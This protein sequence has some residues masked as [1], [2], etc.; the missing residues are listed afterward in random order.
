MKRSL[1]RVILGLSTG[2][3]DSSAALVVDNHLV[4]AAEEERFVRIKHFALFPEHAIRYCLHH[5]RLSPGEVDCVAIGR[6]RWK[7][8]GH[9]LLTALRHPR[10][11]NA[12]LKHFNKEYANTSFEMFLQR[13]CL[14]HAKLVHVEHH[15]AHMASARFVCPEPNTAI[16]SFDG[17]GDFASTAIGVANGNE[18]SILDRVYFP[19]SV[20]FFYTA[21]TQFL[22]FPYFGDEFKVMGLSS[23]GKPRY[24]TELRHLICAKDPFGFELN[25]EAFPILTR[26]IRFSVSEKGQPDTAAF[27]D[28]KYLSNL[29]GIPPRQYRGPV[30]QTHS[31]LAKS[32]QQCFEEI[33]NQLLHQLYDR[34]PSDCIALAGGCSH[35][36]VWV[37]KIPTQTA[38]KRVFVAPASHDAGVSAGAAIYAAHRAIGAENNHW[39]LLGPDYSGRAVPDLSISN[40]VNIRNFSDDGNLIQWMADELAHEKIIGLFNGRMEFGPRALGSRSILADPRKAYMR[41]RLNERVKHREP[42]RPFA[43]SVLW[44]EQDRWFVNPFFCPSMEAVF[45]VRPEAREKIQAVVHADNTTRIH[46]VVRDTQPFYW[47]LIDAFRKRTGIPMIVNTSFNDSEPIVCTEADAVHCF[48]ESDLDHLVVGTQVYSKDLQAQKQTA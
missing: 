1:P 19:H 46:S 44:E 40:N 8:L 3:G 15:L 41:D 30:D 32:V 4:A 25:L 10:L 13:Q 36:S 9:K 5:A 29:I 6:N 26:P 20:G 47:G 16:L 39:A 12:R 24:L 11:V 43:V 35:N 38:F 31:D 28:E 21:L 42:F 18:I 27:Y 17:L 33:G 7:G 2:H 48:L 37:G 45:A 23:Y 14:G 34:F 22:G